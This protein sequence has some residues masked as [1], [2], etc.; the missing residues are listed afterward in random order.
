MSD[1]LGQYPNCIKVSVLRSD[2][3]GCIAVVVASAD[4]CAMLDEEAHDLC[5]S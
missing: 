1:R 2:G 3:E 4:V 5:V